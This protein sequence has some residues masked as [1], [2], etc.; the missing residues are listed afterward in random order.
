MTRHVI[1]TGANKGIGLALCAEILARHSDT[2]VF[3][4]SRDVARGQA[5]AASLGAAAHDRVT[6]V[7]LDVGDGESVAAAA[8]IVSAKLGD[9]KLYGL[10]N[11]AGMLPTAADA[12]AMVDT[13]NVNVRGPKRVVDAFVPLMDA[14]GG[15]I[16]HISSA[17]GPSFVAKCSAERRAAFIDPAVTWDAIEAVMAENVELAK[18]NAPTASFVDKG[19]FSEPGAYYIYGLSKACL[20]MYNHVLARE[21]PSLFVSACTPGFIETDLSAP[22]AARAGKTAADMGMKSPK[23][24]TVSAMALLFG[25]VGESGRYFGSDAVRSPLDKYRAPG[26]AP[27]T[28]E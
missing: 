2:S 4:C 10:V 12:S 18:A 27:Y 13:L 19:F 14:Q 26:D 15:R 11:N 22:M 1:V 21:R 7:P 3:L 9:A 23:D 8:A 25:P 16:V 20:N 24:G 6:V 28:G 5:A 17:A